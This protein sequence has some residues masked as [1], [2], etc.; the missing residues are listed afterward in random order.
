MRN[1]AF[2]TKTKTKKRIITTISLAIIALF[3]VFDLV[4][5]FYAS[6]PVVEPLTDTYESNISENTLSNPSSPG[7]GIPDGADKQAKE[8]SEA[9]KQLAEELEKSFEENTKDAEES[10]VSDIINAVVKTFVNAANTVC[11]WLLKLLFEC[12]DPSFN[13]LY[14][15]E[16]GVMIGLSND[17]IHMSTKEI[18]DGS[19]VLNLIWDFAFSFGLITATLLFFINAGFLV[20]GQSEQIKDTPLALFGRY[21]L[22]LFAI[23]LSRYFIV[24]FIDFFSSIWNNL[25]LNGSI[26][27]IKFAQ[28]NPIT[29]ASN[30]EVVNFFGMPINLVGGHSIKG[31]GLYLY[32]SLLAAVGI[33]FAIEIIKEFVKLFLEM[34]ERYFVLIILLMFFPCA[35]ATITSNNSKRVF[36]SYM[37]M[38]YCQGFLLII[39]T[40]FMAAFT[41]ILLNG[42]WVAG[43]INYLAALA[44]LR[45]CQRVDQYMSQLGLNVAQTGSNLFG[46]VGSAF[47][48]AGSLLR[49]IGNTADRVR[50][51]SGKAFGG[52]STT[53]NKGSQKGGTITGTPLS[54]ASAKSGGSFN[55]TFASNNTVAGA[56]GS[57]FAGKKFTFDSPSGKASAL[58]KEAGMNASVAKQLD[59]CGIKGS[60]IG[61]ITQLD[62]GGKRFSLADANNYPFAQV[63][64]D[65]VYTDSAIHDMNRIAADP[66]E[67][68]NSCA[69]P[70]A[71][72][73]M[74]GDDAIGL[75]KEY[76]EK[77]NMSYDRIVLDSSD[78]PF[79]QNDGDAPS[80]VRCKFQYNGSEAYEMVISS[81][82]GTPNPPSNTTRQTV[83][84]GSVYT[85]LARLV[86]KT[87]NNKNPL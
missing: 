60:D 30:D 19:N 79:Y 49:G 82:A 55:Q 16:N 15:L 51:S 80:T 34:I 77:N 74:T 61:S 66:M 85:K 1:G 44:F 33:F 21:L 20:A 45:V 69:M 9:K 18:F 2:M 27:D 3:I 47:R 17:Y 52:K 59:A 81:A 50:R 4:K 63:V 54:G 40:V 39:N 68:Y 65:K 56:N 75:A 87:D 43:L 58:A 78:R 11:D 72:H 26:E 22:S 13:P 6:E 62:E 7:S 29:L 53:T 32:I 28:F 36:G 37:K 48:G 5:P 12:F 42:G 14:K 84:G 41:T 57:S 35:A 24:A 71:P 23:Y 64:D 83:N 10:I 46:S 67:S 70:P 38:I 86:R 8:D 31:I 76:C 73:N 25:I